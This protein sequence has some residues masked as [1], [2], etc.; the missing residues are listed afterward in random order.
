MSDERLA[1]IRAGIPPEYPTFARL[2]ESTA[3]GDWVVKCGRVL[4]AVVPDY[5]VHV[6]D[7]IAE[8]RA[9]VADLVSEVDR[10]RAELAD[11]PA[12]YGASFAA[13]LADAEARGSHLPPGQAWHQIHPE[14]YE[15]MVDGEPWALDDCAEDELGPEDP[16]PGWYLYG[17]GE[18]A[19]GRHVSA[20]SDTVP[21]A[22]AD[23]V[24]TA[25]R[26]V[27]ATSACTAE[28]P[29][30]TYAPGSMHGGKDGSNW[31]V[32][33]TLTDG[34]P[35][36]CDYTSTVDGRPDRGSEL[37]AL[38]DVQDWPGLDDKTGEVAS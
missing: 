13:E 7:F 36:L 1:E 29:V 37:H 23:A 24:I 4:I 22:T 35:V 12:S 33:G 3:D 2:P 10:L 19:E 9:N 16:G 5:A 20:D 8:S 34:S 17:P 18:Y 32:V 6:A 26:K 38:R 28:A 25:W 30:P 31:V 14:R 15:R 27:V 11:K 21:I